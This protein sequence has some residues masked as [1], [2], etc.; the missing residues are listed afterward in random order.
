VAWVTLGEQSMATSR[1]RRRTV[2]LAGVGGTGA[3]GFTAFHH[4]LQNGTFA[5]ILDL[6]Q[7]PPEFQEAL[8]VA[9]Q[10][11]IA[12]VGADSAFGNRNM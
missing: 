10:G 9:L 7:A 5:E 1:E 4:P 6:F 3:L 11:G 2:A 8:R 12:C